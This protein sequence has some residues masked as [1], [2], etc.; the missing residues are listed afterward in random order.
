MIVFQLNSDHK[1]SKNTPI[2][3][4]HLPYFPCKLLCDF[5][6]SLRTTRIKAAFSSFLQYISSRLSILTKSRNRWF[7]AVF[8]T[9]LLSK[10]LSFF[11]VINCN[12]LRNGV[13]LPL[14]IPGKQ[15][16]PLDFQ[17]FFHLIYYLRKVSYTPCRCFSMNDSGL[18]E[19]TMPTSVRE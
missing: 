9:S 6:N 12:S 13:R 1:V 16:K 10:I 11:A 7:Y 15:E 14:A 17:R 5:E 18:D 2:N 8:E 3:F 19:G 4:L